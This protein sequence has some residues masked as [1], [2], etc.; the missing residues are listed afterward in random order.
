MQQLN[1]SIVDIAKQ[2]KDNANM[3]GRAAM[4]TSDIKTNAVK[5]NQQM[6]E[7]MNAVKDI[8]ASSQNISNSIRNR[9]G[10]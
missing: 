1:A 4:L 8:S 2:T 9:R 5:G 6:G 10:Q 3:A 7:M